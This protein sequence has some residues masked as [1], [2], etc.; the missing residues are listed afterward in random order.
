MQ[1]IH[2][3]GKEITL[4]QKKYDQ[5]TY[6]K[7]KG[8]WVSIQNKD[9][10]YYDWEDF[11]KDHS[12]ELYDDE[13]SLDHQYLVNLQD[14]ARILKLTCDQDIS[15]FHNKYSRLINTGHDIIIFGNY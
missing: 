5:G 8:F 4:T 9:E 2:Y 1:L 12:F 6:I 11:W 10:G 3:S 15:E 13:Y 7:P 14:D